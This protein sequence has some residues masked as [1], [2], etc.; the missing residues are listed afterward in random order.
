[1]RYCVLDKEKVCDNCGDC[2]L[3][4]FDENKVCDNCMACVTGGKTE[5]SI[6]IDKIVM[7]TSAHKVYK[8]K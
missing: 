1:M 2:G 4:E 8:K 3:C 6:T 7:P 5:M